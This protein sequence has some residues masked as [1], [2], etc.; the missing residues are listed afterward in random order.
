MDRGLSPREVCLLFQPERT[1]GSDLA[2]SLN[3][4]P[5]RMKPIQILSVILKHTEFL[6]FYNV[7]K[8][9]NFISWGDFY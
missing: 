4:L 5:L 3:V 6:R 8:R 2:H 9:R 1:E 7:E